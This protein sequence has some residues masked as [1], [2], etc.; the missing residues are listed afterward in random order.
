[1]GNLSKPRKTCPNKILDAILNTLSFCRISLVS[2]AGAVCGWCLRVLAL[3]RSHFAALTSRPI[4]R[5]P[6]A[7]SVFFLSQ[8]PRSTCSRSEVGC[9]L[10]RVGLCVNMSQKLFCWLDSI[11][12][13]QSVQFIKLLMVR[14]G[15]IITKCIT[16]Y[17]PIHVHT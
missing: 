6:T 9:S 15:N 1:M 17:L 7:S 16:V 8:T 12:L 14:S 3:C 10:C 11:Q 5:Q 4:G 2:D 13:I